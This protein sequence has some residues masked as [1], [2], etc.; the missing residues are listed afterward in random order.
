MAEPAP[1][2]ILL[3]VTDILHATA[4]SVH[5]QIDVPLDAIEVGPSEFTPQG[6]AHVDVTLTYV[7]TAVLA[8]GTVDAT[9]R[10]TCVRCLE[11]LD[12][13]VHGAI[14]GFYV[15]H[16]TEHELPEEQEYEF[17][18]G[19]TV[20]VLP[21]IR[22]ALI[23]EFPFAPVHASGCSAVCPQCG[24]PQASCTCNEAPTES[25]FAALKELFRE[26]T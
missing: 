11:E 20:D 26:D 24:E 6:P 10:T 15:P 22:S 19:T 3:D 17:I 21:A 23:V 14:E 12:I 7:G 8:E 9:V 16:G 5:K 1:T 25:P 4:E 18:E 13:A 2:G